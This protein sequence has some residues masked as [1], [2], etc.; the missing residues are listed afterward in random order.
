MSQI[1]F[2]E[3]PEYTE[4][5]PRWDLYQKLYEGK[6]EVISQDQRILWPHEL[7]SRL[8]DGA[9]LRRIRELRSRYMNLIEPV[10]SRYISFLFREEIRVPDSIKTLFGD[11]YE[12]VTG[13]G[14]SFQ[15]FWRDHFGV[16]F[17]LYNNPRVFVDSYG[18]K[19]E[20]VLDSRR[21]NVRPYLELLHPLEV[22][23]WQISSEQVRKGKYDF[24]RCEYEILKTRSS[25]EQEPKFA[26]YSK[27]LAV[28]NG[29]Y[30]IKLYEANKS[31]NTT[32]WAKVDEIVVNEL[33]EIP[34]VA[35]EDNCSFVK[36]A[37]E[38]QLMVYNLS[39]AESSILNA[40]AFQKIFVIGVTSEQA[41]LAFGEYAVNFLPSDASVEAIAPG[42]TNAI[43]GAIL[44]TIDRLFKVSFNQIHSVAGDSK[45]A[46]GA[47]SQREAKQDFIALLRSNIEQIENV[48]NQTITLWAKFK[49]VD[50]FSDKVELS[51][52]I[53]IDDVDR[54]LQIFQAHKDDLK[55]IQLAYR[56][57]LKKRVV[58]LNLPRQEEIFDEIDKT[59]FLQNDQTLLGS[60]RSRLLEQ[61]TGNGRAAITDQAA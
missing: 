23:D 22:K 43:S 34:I 7:E 11:D 3:H 12:D 24:L 39:S 13:T 20:T 19:G 18:I 41:K 50:N 21:L 46:P 61:V 30:V 42:D 4:Y 8:K 16:S 58:D 38:Q 29:S 49:G 5:S 53:T 51:K 17:I 60:T 45:E 26:K 9:K 54:E 28:E 55:K 27:V 15:S 37:V 40:Q 57:I 2:S 10:V 56:E 59:D 32:E 33:P 48:I 52:N 44:A 1:K 31:G 25:A 14:V 6:H 36:D 35:I 47:E